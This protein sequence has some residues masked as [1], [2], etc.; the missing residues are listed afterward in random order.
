MLDASRIE[1]LRSGLIQFLIVVIM[2]F[3][4]L[5]M[6]V[7]YRAETGPAIPGLCILAL[8]TCLYAMARDR[9]L[10]RLQAEL[11]TKALSLERR[12]ETLGQRLKQESAPVE[13]E[14]SSKLAYTDLGERLREL[15]SLYRAISTVNAVMDH[16]HT[17]ETVLRSALDLVGGDVGSIMML[18]SDGET[19]RIMAANGQREDCV[20]QTQNISEGVSGYVIRNGSP[21]MLEGDA[22]D[23]DRF[24]NTVERRNPLAVSMCVP[25]TV[26]GRAIGVLNLGLSTGHEKTLFADDDMRYATLFA[27]HAAVSLENATLLHDQAVYELAEP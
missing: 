10:K 14:A 16:E 3:L 24:E 13:P 1:K 22:K 23:D 6:V 11:I 7:A 2:C 9:Q 5:I 18:Q 8:F 21:L 26:R 19:V 4:A 17:Y 12:A 27:Q 25:V 20:G 15:T